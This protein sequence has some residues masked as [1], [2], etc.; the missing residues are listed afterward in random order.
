MPLLVSTL[1]LPQDSS[2]LRV[3]TMILVEG[4]RQAIRER[5]YNP[6]L[7]LAAQSNSELQIKLNEED[8]SSIRR[9]NGSLSKRDSEPI[10]CGCCSSNN[11]PKQ[12]LN[13]KEEE[14]S[15]GGETTITC[16]CLSCLHSRFATF[17][18]SGMVNP[19]EVPI[20][21]E[22]EPNGELWCRFFGWW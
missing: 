9:S 15:F 1:R 19:C 21:G 10:W 8:H 13:R 3:S 2:K 18:G 12:K 5:S 14:I 16:S 4:R 7:Y 22:L 6:I 20:L 11:C 17:F